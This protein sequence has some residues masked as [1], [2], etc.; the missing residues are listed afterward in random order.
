MPLMELTYQEGALSPEARDQLVE[1]LTTNLLKAEGAPNTEFFR[2][3]TWVLINERPAALTYAGDKSGAGVVKLDVVTPEGA[4][5]DERREQMIQAGTA[6]LREAFGIADEDA[7]KVWVLC[8]DVVDGGWGAGGNVVHYK[9]LVEI[10]KAQR[11]E[12][13]AATA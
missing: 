13:E 7:L 11:A 4:L 12:R 2:S 6:T 9:Q 3:V 10:A 1:D 5:N 8:R